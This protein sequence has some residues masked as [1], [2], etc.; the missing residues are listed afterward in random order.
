MVYRIDQY[1]TEAPVNG[2]ITP[3]GQFP[4]FNPFINRMNA[5]A[6]RL[7]S[8][9][10]PDP[11]E[12]APLAAVVKAQGKVNVIMSIYERQRAL[13]HRV[14]TYNDGPLVWT[15]QWMQNA[16]IAHPNTP[17]DDQMSIFIS[18]LGVP[19]G[20]ELRRLNRAVNLPQWITIREAYN[21]PAAL[22]K[23]F[24]FDNSRG[25]LAGRQP[26]RIQGP[27]CPLYEIEWDL[28]FAQR[29]GKES[30]TVPLAELQARDYGVGVR[31][32]TSSRVSS[33]VS[34]WIDS[35]LAASVNECLSVR[36]TLVTYYTHLPY[37]G[38]LWFGF[39]NAVRCTLEKAVQKGLTF[40]GD[41]LDDEISGP[42]EMKDLFLWFDRN[43]NSKS[44]STELL[45]IKDTGVT[46]LFF[47]HHKRK[48]DGFLVAERGFELKSTD[49][50]R[51]VLPSVDWYGSLNEARKR[52][53]NKR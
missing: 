27:Y 34:N 35:I 29:F 31:W 43:Q 11:N 46:K 17:A 52:R 47:K 3:T 12:I 49:G 13:A 51:V 40:L 1:L 39:P 6:N 53:A 45:K 30:R 37:E 10:F 18:D 28:D 16:L 42:D 8:L 5:K 25:C 7:A 24:V 41:L 36:G 33:V 26:I 19:V 23:E 50:S 44:E 14:F 2:L 22:N 48:R 38:V 32:D 4:E 20:Y 9:L 15:T 21:P